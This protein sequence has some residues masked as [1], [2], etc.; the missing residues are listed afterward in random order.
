MTATITRTE[1]VAL[2]E[3][4]GVLFGC[5]TEAIY[6]EDNIDGAVQLAPLEDA[7]LRE[8][9][10]E[11]WRAEQEHPET[12]HR[13]R[14]IRTLIVKSMRID[15]DQD[16][17]ALVKNRKHARA[18]KSEARAAVQDC[19]RRLSVRERELVGYDQGE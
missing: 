5:I 17:L 9:A 6:L 4:E 10:Q 8:A 18:I 15:D 13:M 14:R 19:E 1:A 7:L 3:R 16:A 2:A 11:A 12:A